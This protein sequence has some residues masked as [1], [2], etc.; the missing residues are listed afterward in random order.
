MQLEQKVTA[1]SLQTLFLQMAQP[2]VVLWSFSL[3]QIPNRA[4]LAA[5]CC[6]PVFWFSAKGIPVTWHGSQRSSRGRTLFEDLMVQNGRTKATPNL[7]RTS[8]WEMLFSW[9]LVSFTST[10]TFTTATPNRAKKH[11]H[12]PTACSTA[13]GIVR[14]FLVQTVNSTL[15][16]VVKFKNFPVFPLYSSTLGVWS[17]DDINTTALL[18]FGTWNHCFHCF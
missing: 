3:R 9:L 12:W 14:A 16:W 6:S 18:F 15:C 5:E 13:C 11:Y 1:C 17:I 4:R 8:Q 10:E 2:R 7:M